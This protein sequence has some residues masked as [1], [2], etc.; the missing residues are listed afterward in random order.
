MMK[1]ANAAI[2]H[3]SHFFTESP[4]NI[5]SGL[6]PDLSS[7]ASVAAFCDTAGLVGCLTDAG[8]MGATPVR[9]VGAGVNCPGWIAPNCMSVS[10]FCVYRLRVAKYSAPAPSAING[11]ARE[12]SNFVPVSV[13]CV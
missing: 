7:T 9:C 2:A 12:M 4:E 5:V 1:T 11:N 3:G 10:C 13:G 6:M 8:E